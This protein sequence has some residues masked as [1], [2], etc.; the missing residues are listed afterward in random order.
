VTISGGGSIQARGTSHRV[1]RAI[2]GGITRIE[3]F[4]LV[5]SRP[6]R[7]TDLGLELAR[8]LEIREYDPIDGVI[9]F[10]LLIDGESAWFGMG[11]DR[12]EGLLQAIMMAAG[13]EPETPND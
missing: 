10:E 6:G 9:P 8:S 5:P 7:T 11:D 4:L 2:V 1:G 3:Q 12:V 13:Q